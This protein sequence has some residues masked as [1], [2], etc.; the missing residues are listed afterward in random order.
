MKVDRV[1]RK[2]QRGYV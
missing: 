1:R 2:E